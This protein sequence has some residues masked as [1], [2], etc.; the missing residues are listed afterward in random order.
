MLRL[1]VLTFIQSI[2][3]FS[4]A[5]ADDTSS[6][7][8]AQFVREL[9]IRSGFGSG[10]WAIGLLL[11]PNTDTDFD[12]AGT[13]FGLGITQSFYRPHAFGYKWGAN[14]ESLKAAQDSNLNFLNIDPSVSYAPNSSGY[15]LVG[16]NYSFPLTK[17]VLETELAGSLGYQ[18]GGGVYI[19]PKWNI[20]AIYR[21]IG[22]RGER[23]AGPRLPTKD[24]DRL[25]SSGLLVRASYVLN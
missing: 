23:L 12:A 21:D 20:E 1:F 19:G 16:L 25:S 11:S 5:A 24:L 14:L 4:Q 3:I 6:F 8:I 17:T 9:K 22:F 13:A 10:S 18:A 7:N 2:F 15:F